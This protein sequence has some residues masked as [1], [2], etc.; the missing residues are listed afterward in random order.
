M[1]MKGFMTNVLSRIDELCD[2]IVTNVHDNPS[3]AIMA[4]ET[5]YNVVRCEAGYNNF[6]NNVKPK[7]SN[8]EKKA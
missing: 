4:A 8:D 1:Q 7:T 2:A 5:L 3:V 6:M